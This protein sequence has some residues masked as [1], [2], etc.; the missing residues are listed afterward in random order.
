MVRIMIVLLV[1]G[2]SF[3]GWK[4]LEQ[5]EEISLY[6]SAMAP[7]GQVEQDMTVIQDAA[8]K[9]TSRNKLKEQE[10]IKGD[11]TDQ[12]SIAEYVRRLCQGDNVQWGAV[13]IGKARDAPNLKGYTDFTYTVEHSDKKDAVGRGNIAN[14]FWLLERGSSKLK[15]TEIHIDAA[16]K[17]KPHEIPED[18]WNVDFEVTVRVPGEVGR[19]R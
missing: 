11:I 13:S 16:G 1:L 2:S 17:S 15:V 18:S 7:G 5:R 10:G 12:G 4:V 19:S 8:Y 6:E 3:L 14:L 9:Y